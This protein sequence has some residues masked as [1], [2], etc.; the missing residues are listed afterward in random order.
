[1]NDIDVVGFVGMKARLWSYSASHDRLSLELSDGNKRFFLV[2]YFCDRIDLPW[3]WMFTSPVIDRDEN[4][5][6]YNFSDEYNAEK[7]KIVF[8]DAVVLSVEEHQEKYH[9]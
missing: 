1:M 9:C 5:K 4:L 6:K 3:S 7:I 8:S 2:F